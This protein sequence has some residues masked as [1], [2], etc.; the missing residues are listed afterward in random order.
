MTKQR[1]STNSRTCH[2]VIFSLILAVC[3]G[4]FVTALIYIY[5]PDEPCQYANG[6]ITSELE[7]PDT[8]EVKAYVVNYSEINTCE[9]HDKYIE[10]IAV[11]NNVLVDDVVLICSQKGN[12]CLAYSPNSS[13][14][15]IPKNKAVIVVYFRPRSRRL[16]QLNE[17]C[18]GNTTVCGTLWTISPKVFD[19][20]NQL[21]TTNMCEVL[22]CGTGMAVC[23][24]SQYNDTE[25]CRKANETWIPS[26]LDNN[27]S[28]CAHADS[29]TS[30][31]CQWEEDQDGEINCTGGRDCKD[32]TTTEKQCKP[33]WCSEQTS[34]SEHCKTVEEQGC[35]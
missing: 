18:V 32:W 28:Y 29:L 24:D 11:K 27:P 22:L 17:T 23:S 30:N 4:A 25:T 16:R 19:T 6:A 26:I 15:N 7:V 21:R 34:D 31:K 3:V 13:S 33:F 8:A 20:L 35:E 5:W 12:T 14:E 1:R 2:Y 9:K 10:G